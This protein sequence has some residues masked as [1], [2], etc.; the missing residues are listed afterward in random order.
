MKHR[1]LK[2]L[3]LIALLASIAAAQDVASFEKRITVKKLANG[4]TILI[5]ERPEAPVFSFFTLVDAGS[6]QDPMGKTGLAHMFEHMAFKGTD[7]IG[8]K[9]YSAEKPALE[10]VET[11]YAA[12]LRERDK[13]VGRDEAKLKQ[14]E[15]GWKDAIAEADKY[16]VP[17]QFGKIIEQSGGQDLNA[18][19]DYDETEYHYSLPTNRLELWAYLES[20][21]FL[22]PVMRE[23]YKERN[24]VI[25]ERRM[26]TDSNPIGRLLE[27]FGASA[28]EAHPYHR[29]T[30]GWMSDLNSFSA[31]D[32]KKFFDEYYV[33]ANMVVAV[34]GDVKAA[35]VLPIL[36][37]YFGRLP[38]S[39]KSDETT[40]K[41]PPQNS[42][43]KVVL[44]DKSQ[45]LYLEGYHRPDYMSKDDA[46]YDAITDLM[47]EGR[48][49]RL[50]R[51]LVRDK[52]IAAFSAGFSGLPGIKYPHLFA[53]YAFPLPG[54]APQ[55]VADAIHVEIERLKKED[56]SD[57][58]LKMIKTRAKANLIRGLA[59]NE[60]LANQLATY[61][62]RY[63]DWRE[64]FR[65]VDRID[66]VTK[67]DIRRVANETFNDTNRTVGIIENVPGGGEGGEQ[68]PAERSS[69]DEGSPDQGGSR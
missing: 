35:D 38:A 12:Y 55:E 6:V 62:T 24:V 59:E 45:P 42:E 1:I 4:L 27:Q 31:T 22:H 26:R 29:P 49:S 5:C 66:R 53:F 40:T 19:T 3:A 15:K 67:A 69:S 11:T 28:F 44:K 36:E 47:S 9:D 58:E 18:S 68:A 7:T 21:R 37:K 2:S 65:S 52:K 33:P 43:R 46:V 23:F 64:L 63:G 34:A 56:I 10:K 39:E 54:H 25:E 48:T 16:V 20:E 61:Q 50:Y 32:A 13:T 60:G 17:N 57:E 14:L 8:T 30:V 51:A 41:E